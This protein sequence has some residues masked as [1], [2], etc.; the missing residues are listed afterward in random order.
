MGAERFAEEDKKKTEKVDAVQ[1]FDNYLDALE[2]AIKD[3]KGIG[4]KMDDE[5]RTTI[6]AAVSKGRSWLRAKSGS[7]NPELIKE[8]H[9]DIESVCGEIMTK[10]YGSKGG[11]G[12]SQEEE[13]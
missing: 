10:Y 13:G 5:E 9:K 1:S 12:A 6:D 4:G 11:S 3:K 2:K 8:K 7:A